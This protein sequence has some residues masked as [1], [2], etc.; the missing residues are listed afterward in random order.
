MSRRLSFIMMCLFVFSLIVGSYGGSLG[1]AEAAESKAKPQYGGILKIVDDYRITFLGYPQKMTAGWVMRAAA[2]AI[3][4]LLRIDEQGRSIPW[5]AT[6]YKTDPNAAT[7]TLALRKGIKFH[8]GTDF[9]AEAV[10]WNLD[11]AISEKQFGS[12]IMKSV[13][14][15]DPNTVRINLKQWDNTVL[16]MLSYSYIAMMISPTAFKK[17]GEEWCANNPVGTGPFRFVSWEKDL[18]ITYKKFEGYWQKGKPYLDGIEVHYIADK[19]VA[20]LGFRKD[21]T[22]LLLEPLFEDLT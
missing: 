17:N 7:I 19:T 2:P 20:G 4:T 11:Q 21:E 8:D 18:K 3:E 1:I 10:K 9:N 5:L 6:S 16:G 14:V 12:V 13:D 15:V 22:H